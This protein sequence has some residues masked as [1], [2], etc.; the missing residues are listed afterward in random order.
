M[1]CVFTSI[2]SIASMDVWLNFCNSLVSSQSGAFQTP[3]CS[4]ARLANVWRRHFRSYEYSIKR[5]PS[6]CTCTR[7]TQQAYSDLL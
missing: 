2:S 4:L 3:G 6:L 5:T 1:S 7:L